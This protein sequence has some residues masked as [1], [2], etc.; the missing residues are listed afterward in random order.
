MC[1]GGGPFALDVLLQVMRQQGVMKNT[2]MCKA[3]ASA[4]EKGK[5]PKRALE[6]FQAMRQQG[7]VPNVIT[8]NVF[9]SACAESMLL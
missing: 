9:I 7:V 3:L 6:V 2:V 1:P 5:Q 8:S 4:S